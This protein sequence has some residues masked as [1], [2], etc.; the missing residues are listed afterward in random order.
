MR[1][2]LFASQPLSR[3]KSLR[4]TG[5]LIGI[6]SITDVQGAD[7]AFVSNGLRSNMPTTKTLDE[8]AGDSYYQDADTY[9]DRARSVF[10]HENVDFLADEGDNYFT[11]GPFNLFVRAYYADS[12]HA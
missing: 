11:A 9:W 8:D 12:K 4:S 6:A 3:K 7:I 2:I 10:G 5:R 1:W